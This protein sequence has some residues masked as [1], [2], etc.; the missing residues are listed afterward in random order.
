M[1]D[2]REVGEDLGAY[3]KSCKPSVQQLQ[4]FLS[5]LLAGDD[6]LG[7]AKDL[8]AR[9]SF[10]TLRGDIETGMGNSRRLAIQAELSAVYLPD[11]VTKLDQV[12]QGL[13][14][15]RLRAD[16]N[17]LSGEAAAE[18]DGKSQ[19]R[20]VGKS[21]SNDS[22]LIR[23]VTPVEDSEAEAP[24]SS[25]HLDDETPY[26]YTTN[27]HVL[28][29]LTFFTFNLY[30]YVWMYLFWSHLKERSKKVEEPFY[31][32]NKS[33]VPFWSAWFNHFYIVGTARRIRRRLQLL[34]RESAATQPWVAFVFVSMLP[35]AADRLQEKYFNNSPSVNDNFL[36]FL[37]L[38]AVQV[39]ASYQVFRLQRLANQAVLIESPTSRIRKRPTILQLLVIS[40]GFVIWFLWAVATIVPDEVLNS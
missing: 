40:I 12:I 18:V 16:G 33:I 22:A 25:V 17:A 31:P 34:G 3:I 7:A 38:S 10:Q 2:Y 24:L 39:L 28:L 19:E 37:A 21:T 20:F 11:V 27:P 30:D 26:F 32:K 35:P 5:D 8:V 13:L 15:H 6:I 4:A 9:P 1:T 23:S 14:D 29:A 36:V